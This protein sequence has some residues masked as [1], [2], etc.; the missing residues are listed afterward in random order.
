MNIQRWQA[1]ADI[2]SWRF[3]LALF[4]FKSLENNVADDHYNF[5]TYNYYSSF[6]QHYCK[7]KK[8]IT[9][10]VRKMIPKRYYALL[11]SNVLGSQ[12]L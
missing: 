3:T 8:I 7:R 12:I 6:L 1:E 10:K 11:L 9:Q 5:D 2:C 4:N